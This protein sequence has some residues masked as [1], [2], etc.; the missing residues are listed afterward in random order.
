MNMKK[1]IIPV[2]ATVVILASGTVSCSDFLEQSNP[3]AVTSDSY[4]N[5]EEEAQAMLVGCYNVLLKQGLY[6]NYYNSADP[7]SLDCFGTYDGDSGWW[8]WSPAENALYWGGL[9]ASC[10]LVDNVWKACYMGVARCNEVINKVPLMG[11]DK[12]PSAAAERIVAEARFL[13]AFYYYY[14]TQY[15]RDVP[16]SK[17]PTATG[18]IEASKKEVVT[19]F[20]IDELND[21]VN[22][23]SL[24]RTLDAGDRGRATL[25]AAYGLLCRVALYNERWQEASDAASRV[26][27][28]GYSLEPDY[29]HLFSEAGCTSN[30]IIFSV[31]F[32]QSAD[33]TSNATCGFLSTTCQGE[34]VSWEP[35]NN[36][37][38]LAYYD[39]EGIPSEKSST[40]N[41]TDPETMDPRYGYCFEGFQSSWVSEDWIN[42]T[43]VVTAYI[44]KYVNWTDPANNWKDDQ[45]YYVIRYADVLLMKAEA[46]I[47]LGDDKGAMQLIDQ[48]RDRE[49]V[50]MPHVDADEIAYHGSLLNVLKH[51]RRVE[52]A[53]E[54]FR[55]ADLKRW[56]DYDQLRE[57][58][59]VGPERCKVWPIP[60][61]ELDNN[62]KLSQA[63]EW[64]G[65]G[66]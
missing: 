28:L 19:Q 42:W 38:L 18:Y 31:R 49:S 1:T 7:R 37:I 11:E 48:V 56:G 20:I 32:N 59:S 30:E 45:D 16:L 6:Y 35:V 26:M 54:G 29:L 46:L 47:H 62:P 53:F 9:T 10:D 5:N 34:H 24:P 14:L 50:K 40:A 2:L 39:K 15:F 66:E 25:G 17:E 13:R 43:E 60:Q 12:I 33:P 64:G 22:G 23:G 21:I 44:N 58:G 3:N 8:F 61:S 51:E 4:W 41:L 55:Y 36:N 63:P 52:L 65:D 27:G 57:Y